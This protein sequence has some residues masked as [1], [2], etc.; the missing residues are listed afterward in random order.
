MAFS[1]TISSIDTHG[2]NLQLKIRWNYE[3]VA[4]TIVVT[5]KPLSFCSKSLLPYC[6]A[7]LLLIDLL[8]CCP[9]MYKG[10][11]GVCTSYNLLRLWSSNKCIIREHCHEVV[12]GF[13]VELSRKQVAWSLCSIPQARVLCNHFLR[14]KGK[15]VSMWFLSITEEKQGKKGDTLLSLVTW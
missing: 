2:K 4:S 14:S 1:V 12:Y 15:G 3:R 11:Y 5:L 7:Q 6:Y 10:F 8:F 13:R 9:L